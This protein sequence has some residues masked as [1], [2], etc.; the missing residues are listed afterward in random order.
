MSSV[1]GGAPVCLV[2]LVGYSVSSVLGA[3]LF[4]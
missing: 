4:V 3:G 2:C 1:L